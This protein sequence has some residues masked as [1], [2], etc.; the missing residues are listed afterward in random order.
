MQTG[1][2]G[3]PRV[4]IIIGGGGPKRTPIL[5]GTVGE[6]TDQLG[7]AADAGVQR[8]YLQVLD[9]ADLDHVALL[10]AEVLPALR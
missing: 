8:M 9:L 5:I 10:G 4:P 7:A 6:V 2:T 1:R 3:T